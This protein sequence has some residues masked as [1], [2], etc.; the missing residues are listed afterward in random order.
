MISKSL[1]LCFC[2]VLLLTGCAATQIALEKKDL[3]VETKMSETIFLDIENEPEKT[4][5][6]DIKNTSDKDI[7]IVP[8]VVQELQNR[9][10]DVKTS[11]KDAYYILQGNI[12]YVGKA[13]PSALREATLSGFGGPLAGLAAGGLIGGAA[14][15]GKGAAYGMGIGAVVGGV[16]EHVAGSLVKDVTFTIVTD[17]MISEKS[18]EIVDQT[19]KSDLQQGSGSKIIQTSQQ[20]TTRKKYQTRVVSTANKVNLKLEEA[21]NPLI[22][23]LSKAI[24]GVF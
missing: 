1:L 9:G 13:D 24:A 7:N 3:K 23:T 6:I 19:V 4:I 16:A 14:G 20:T 10:Y 18:K 8:F 11:P 17:L 12:L 2:F 21:I 5:Y 22:Q 15:G